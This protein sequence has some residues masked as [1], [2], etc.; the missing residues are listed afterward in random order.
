MIEK[1]PVGQVQFQ[2]G[3]DFQKSLLLLLTKDPGFANLVLRYV[4]ESYFDN[5][6]FKWVYGYILRYKAKYNAI[7]SMSVLLEEA[8]SLKTENRELYCISLEG[9]IGSDLSNEEWIRDKIIDF[10][11]RN[12]FVDAFQQ[13]K[14]KYNSGE[15]D[16]A[17]STMMLAMDD[18]YRASMVNEDR[19]WF[20]E[21]FN[22]RYSDRLSGSN[23]CISTGIHELDKVL[24][25][26]LSLTEV[27]LWIALAKRGKT[28]ILTNHGVQAVR[29]SLKNVLHVVLEGSVGLVANRYDT[30][31]AQEDYNLVKKGVM[32]EKVYRNLLTEYQMLSKKLVIRGYTD[33]WDTTIEDIHLEMKDL[34][35]LYN[36]EPQLIIIDYGDLLKGRG[37]YR[38]ETSSQRAAFRDMKSLANRG[39][40]IWTA[41]QGQRPAKD[42]ENSTKLLT[43]VDVA[44]CYDKVRSVDFI[45]SINQTKEERERHKARLYAEL[46]RDNEAGA[47]IDI[48]VDFTKMTFK[49]IRGNK[50]IQQKEIPHSISYRNGLKQVKAPI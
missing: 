23:E 21:S 18:I 20:F 1:S 5:D 39:Y 30:I 46:Y 32:N 9:I 4:K 11:K 42:F 2:F 41:A 37:K 45:G 44:D 12:I 15:V 26:G 25:G 48:D 35:R 10:I 24:G 28:T 17:Y 33:R 40:G 47:V 7:P 19:E 16:S 31:F 13:S 34:K 43:Q 6:F 22:Q 38:D 29:R 14:D 8:R 27:G 3:I 36:W 50:K 49:S